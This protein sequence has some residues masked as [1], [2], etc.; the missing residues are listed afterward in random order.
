MGF[1]GRKKKVQHCK[2]DYRVWAKP[3][4]SPVEHCYSFFSKTLLLS[5]Q[6][7]EGWA[8]PGKWACLF[9]WGLVL[10]VPFETYNHSS[11]LPFNI[12]D[13]MVCYVLI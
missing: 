5:V 9:P 7:T 4:Q 10:T 13:T 8:M 12:D 6:N 1:E 2:R 3:W 11:V